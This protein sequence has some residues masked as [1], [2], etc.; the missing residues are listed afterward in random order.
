MCEIGC[1]SVLGGHLLD[2]GVGD[3]AAELTSGEQVDDG[4]FP[5]DH[6]AVQC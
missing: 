2:E 5:S 1:S 3:G 4:E 6:H